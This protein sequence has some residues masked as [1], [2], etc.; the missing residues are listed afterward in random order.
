MNKIQYIKENFGNFY[1]DN[2][3]E[4]GTLQGTKYDGCST[5][6]R[7][8]LN[9]LVRMTKPTSILEIGSYHYETTKSMSD[10]M[11]TYLS[12]SEGIIH[13][14]DIKYGGY[15]GLGTQTGLHQRIKVMYWYPYKTNY[16]VWKLTDEGVVYKDFLK[17]T[18]EELFNMNNHI[19]KEVS[20]KNGY[21]LIFID[22]DHSYEGVKKDWEHALEFS[23]H[24]TLIVIDNIWDVRLKEVRRFYDEIKTTKWDFEE[25]N[26]MNRNL[27]QDTGIL[28]K[29]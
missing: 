8:C 18:N 5:H 15:D 10:G 12:D 24:E 7:S 2:G 3:P 25:W 9:T 26:D 21:D 19:L 27:V 22:G 16:D 4:N 28:L 17:Y 20:P 11:D 6:C 29:Y 13:T 14:F 1:V 23:H